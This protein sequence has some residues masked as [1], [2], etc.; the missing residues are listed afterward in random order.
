MLT[1]SGHRSLLQRIARK[2]MLDK[3]FIIEFPLSALTRINKIADVSVPVP[4]GT[5]DQRSL[6]WCSIDNDDSEDLDQLTVAMDLPSGEVKILI[7]I[8]DVDSLVDKNSDLE[9]HARANTTS[10]YTSAQIFPM[11]PEKL[12]TDL[13]SLRFAKDRL[14]LVVEFVVAEDG[15]V[16]NQDVYRS[17]V[18]N[19]AKLAYHSTSAWLEGTGSTPK[20]IDSVNGAKGLF[21]RLFNRFS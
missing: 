10:V 4:A 13:T 20:E 21:S 16:K 11:L 1:A 8:A 15:S 9:E 6:L 3:G 2:S 7:A 14:A 19:K 12:S 18:Q 17:V 5:R